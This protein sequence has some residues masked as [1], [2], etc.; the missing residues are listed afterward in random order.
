MAN[1]IHLSV[2]PDIV[3]PNS[4]WDM[5]FLEDLLQDMPDSDRIVFIIPGAYQWDVIP[6]INSKLAEHKKVL[7]FITS[8][9]EGNF[10]C[11]KLSHPDM[12]HYRQYGYCKD[13]K[14]FPIG[15]T[16]ETRKRLK[17][18]GLTEKNIRLF[19]S[20]QL[21]SDER[22]DMF[23]KVARVPNAVLF[24]TNGFTKGLKFDEYYD[25]LAHA[26]FAPS[27][28]GHVSPDSF[29]FY[30]A[31]EAGAIP[32]EF[33]HYMVKL[34]PD[35]P[36]KAELNEMFS[37]WIRTKV[38]LKQ[39]LKK[40]LG[41]QEAMTIIVPTSPIPSHPS[42]EIIE[43]T[44]KSIRE[45]TSMDIIITIDGI[46]DEQQQMAG[47][48]KEY[49]RRLLWKCNFEWENVMPIFFTEHVHQSGMIKEALKHVTT[50]LLMYVEHDTPLSSDEIPWEMISKV[51]LQGDANVIRFHYEDKIP[52]EHEYLMLHDHDI[53][54]FTATKQWSQRP[55]V[56]RTD[57]Y[58]DLMQYFSPDSN[59]FIE[60][61]LYTQCVS[62]E[63]DAWRVYIYTPPGGIKR[64]LNLDG[65]AG[66]R[67][68]DQEGEQ[69]W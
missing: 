33:P 47:F 43:K 9:E 67:K 69:K 29:R 60:D 13:E 40:D 61:R 11:E 63:F 12:I 5:A 38:K 62:G 57:F 45:H 3:P 8:D 23:A 18:I 10:D 56:A 17:E 53:P 27:P 30:E 55:H 48:Y 34:F 51:L 42:T 2:K 16:S 4:Y 20:G 24:G 35:F 49:V 19:F 1:I 7:V 66:D 31:L 54:F 50:P 22:R 44:I 39:Q 59:C 28:G 52:K 68:F 37:W 6:A 26:I 14:Y 41:I 46:R 65:R 32:T 25:Y 36:L 21:N 15:Y 64:S 58:T